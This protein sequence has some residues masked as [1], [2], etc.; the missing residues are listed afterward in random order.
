MIDDLLCLL[1]DKIN[2]FYN[3]FLMWR[4]DGSNLIDISHLQM[5]ELIKDIQKNFKFFD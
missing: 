5:D 2:I 1:R 4:N 3:F